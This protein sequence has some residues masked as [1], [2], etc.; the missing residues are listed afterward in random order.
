MDST[1]AFQFIGCESMK[2]LQSVPAAPAEWNPPKISGTF[3]LKFFYD[4]DRVCIGAG[5]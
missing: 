1:D 3:C 5:N 2:A 4:A